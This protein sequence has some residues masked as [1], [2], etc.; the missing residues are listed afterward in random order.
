MEFNIDAIET[1]TIKYNLILKSC[2]VKFRH[3]V[4]YF[5]LLCLCLRKVV[6]QKTLLVYLKGCCSY[7]NKYFFSK[8]GTKYNLQII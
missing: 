6:N 1:L 2:Y 4:L 8:C 3:L 5:R 7:V